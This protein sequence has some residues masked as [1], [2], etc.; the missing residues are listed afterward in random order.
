MGE[1]R[2]EGTPLPSLEGPRGERLVRFLDRMLVSPAEKIARQT[3]SMGTG[4]CTGK[5]VEV[6]SPGVLFE[7]VFTGWSGYAKAGR[8]IV[9]RLANHLYVQ[10]AHSL[11]P[12]WS[13]PPSEARISA[14][15]RTRV[16]ETSPWIRFFGPDSKATPTGKRKR[17]I[18]TMMETERIH[19]DMVRQVNEKFDELWTPT[20]WNLEAFV[21][22]GL[23][24]PGKTVH[25]GVDGVTYRP[26]PGSKLPAC[27]LLST[28]KAG[29]IET[30]EGFLFISVGLPSFRKGFDLLSRAFE[31]A[32]A[33]DPDAALVCAVTHSSANVEALASCSK[34]KSRIYALEGQYDEHQMAKIYS[35]CQA[36]ATASRGE[37]WNL[38]LCE[39][40]AC[41]LPVICGNNTSH[42]EV[43][44]KD[45]FMF[46]AEGTA[47]VVGAESVSPWYKGVPFTVFGKKSLAELVDLL[48][49]VRANGRGVRNKA[50]ALRRKMLWEW[51]WDSAAKTV[52][53]RALEAQG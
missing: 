49:L 53:A 35:A 12:G 24:V 23:K 8:E 6:F 21:R 3:E 34:M 41:G 45:A 30:P 22:S 25:L 13:H 28:S 47:P 38:P 4:C 14:L 39:A 48:R 11:R 46:K 40:S 27:K 29:R 16:P 31:I 43:A 20:Q 18:Y 42:N 2:P 33:K 7:G 19:E 36:Y 17:I 9:F 15:E 37:G 5:D 52:A 44:G 32:F 10:L 51:T 50:E 1:E 26:I